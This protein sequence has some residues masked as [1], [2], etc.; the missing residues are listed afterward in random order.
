MKQIKAL[1]KVELCNLYGL[2]VLKHTKDPIERRKKLV[3]YGII[4]L[5][6]LFVIAYS[7]AQSFALISLGAGS[8]VPSYLIVM[9]GILSLML[10]VF[11]TGGVLFRKNSFDI[12]SSL[13]LSDGAVVFSRFLRLYTESL[14]ISLLIMLPGLVV[15]AV[16]CDT[17]AMF[18]ISALL[19]IIAAPLIPVAIATA[20]GALITGIASRMK[21]KSIAEAVLSIIV[22][23]GVFMLSSSLSGTESEMTEE[24]MLQLIGSISDILGKIYPPAVMFGN[25]AV[26]GDIISL[27]LFIGI[28]AAAFAAVALIVSLNFRRICQRLHGTYAKHSYKMQA[29]QQT[30]LTKALVQREAKRYFSSGVYVTNTIIGPILAVAMCVALIFVD[31]N[32]LL[33]ELP[34][35]ININAAL[36]FV[37]A[38]VLC[39]MNPS[40]CSI[41]MEG[42][43]WWIT[44]SL[45]LSAKNIISGKLLFSLCLL[46]PFYVVAEIVVMATQSF[47][48]MERIWFILVPVITA[49]F[50]SVF[51]IFVNLKFPKLQWETEVEIVKQSASSMIGGLVGALAVIVFA[52]IAA[53][54][55]SQFSL[56][57]NACVCVVLFV[58]TLLMYRSC[59]KKD[60]R[61]I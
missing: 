26:N 8:A 56:V 1:A 21:H 10:A 51:G 33:P 47:D 18:Y 31:V 37:F 55:P 23:L 34:I 35:E 32:T 7:G 59:H 54:V 9:S 46:A 53:V 52:L 40:A 20:V 39:M 24:M 42:K 4:A 49:V 41:S 14:I 2:N 38:A 5:L 30:S 22:I 15:Y 3:V 16:M 44:M 60:L 13:P 17:N 50:S 29:Q 45:P 48:I 43:Q 61:D 27:A 57:F 25:S 12:I 11:K 36:P 58:I 6:L 28:S 19:G